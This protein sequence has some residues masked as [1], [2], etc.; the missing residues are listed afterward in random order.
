MGWFKSQMWKVLEWKD[1][2][3]DTMVHR[4]DMQGKEIMSGSQLT[5][6]ESQAGV[7]VHQGKIADVF[8]PG[9]HK[10]TTRNLPI[11]SAIGS[12]WY[13]GESRFKAELYFVNTKQFVDCK[14]GTNNPITMR[15]KEFGAVRVRAFG[16]Y[17]F[18]VN[19]PAEFLREVF[20]T[21]GKFGVQD[22]ESNLKSILV[23]QMSDTIAESGISALDM[24]M[25]YQE[26]GNMIRDNAQAK[27]DAIGLELTDFNIINISLPEAVEKAIDERAS[28]GILADQMGT[29]TQKKAADALG[30]AAKNPGSMGTFMGIGLGAQAGGILGTAFG[31]A[32]NAQNKPKDSK[33][34][35][36][37][38]AKISATAKFCP[39]CGKKLVSGNTC[40][41]CGK[42]VGEGAKFCPECGEKLN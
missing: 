27:F 35:P 32:Q 17:S 30:D 34:C 7:F 21:N 24:A 22:I 37:C 40:P 11:L 16:N 28:L 6:R 42:P 25:N 33:F 36:V 15:D 1:E 5:V 26:F 23:S 29:Y 4:F 14:W 41:S 13:Q 12:I 10:L 38:G 18:R 19:D 31:S 9:Q 3:Q 20:G 8:G 39:E 2:S